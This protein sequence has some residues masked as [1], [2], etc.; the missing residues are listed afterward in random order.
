MSPKEDVG[1]IK[2]RIL[3]SIT[4]WQKSCYFLDNVGKYGRAGQATEDTV[5]RAFHAG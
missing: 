1:K 4:P 2:T 5:T 3:C